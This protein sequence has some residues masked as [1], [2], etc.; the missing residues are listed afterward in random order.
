MNNMSAGLP[1]Y[2]KLGLISAN[3]VMMLQ[4][5]NKPL[6]IIALVH[7]LENFGSLY[8]ATTSSTSYWGCLELLLYLWYNLI[9]REHAIDITSWQLTLTTYNSSHNNTIPGALSP[10]TILGTVDTCLVSIFFI[11]MQNLVSKGSQKLVH[12]QKSFYPTSYYKLATLIKI[13][14]QMWGSTLIRKRKQTV[15]QKV[16]KVEIVTCKKEDRQI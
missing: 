16:S 5:I 11:H 2:Y 8:C 13:F 3:R 14:F 4:N 7:G 15:M 9:I 1:I 6:V 12:L 10:H